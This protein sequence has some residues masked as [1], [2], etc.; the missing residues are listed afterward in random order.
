MTILT[1]WVKVWS[2][3]CIPPTEC[4][5]HWNLP[6][7][8]VIALPKYLNCMCGYSS[9]FLL[10]MTQAFPQAILVS[11]FTWEMN[12]DGLIVSNWLCVEG[13][14]PETQDFLSEM[15]LNILEELIHWMF[16][17]NSDHLCDTNWYL[18][19]FHLCIQL[20]IF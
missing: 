3:S 14:M 16:F 2:I 17:Y 19:V 11:W 4:L 1:P 12:A 18:S 8:R 6:E 13:M 15:L 20:F 10:Y 5:S 9:N 7:P